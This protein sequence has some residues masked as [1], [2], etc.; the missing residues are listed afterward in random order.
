[1]VAP[2]GAHLPRPGRGRCRGCRS[3]R[4]RALCAASTSS[5]SM[6]GSGLVADPGFIAVAPGNGR[7]QRGAGFGLPPGVDDRAAPV[8][9][10][11]PIPFPRVGLIGS[12][13]VPSSRS[14]LRLWRVTGSSP[15]RIE[16][17]DRGRRGVEDGHAQ[18]VDRLPEAAEVGVIGNA[19]EHDAGR[20]HSSAGRRRRSCGR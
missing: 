5:G 3:P 19:V 11:A 20:A 14:D 10:H 16:R 9:D 4:R 1:M 15:S 17:A 6:P 8:A 2:H 18:A 12:P 7:D 13:T